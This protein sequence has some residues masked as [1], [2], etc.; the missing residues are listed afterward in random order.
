MD[1]NLSG[2]CLDRLALASDPQGLM[3]QT[4]LIAPSDA[5]LTEA[6]SK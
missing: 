6:A 5:I 3:S 4:K 1:W 2:F